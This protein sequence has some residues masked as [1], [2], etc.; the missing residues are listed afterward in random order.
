[1]EHCHRSLY[2]TRSKPVISAPC[3]FDKVHSKRSSSEETSQHSLKCWGCRYSNSLNSVGQRVTRYRRGESHVLTVKA[4]SN[5]VVIEEQRAWLKYTGRIR[6]K[7]TIPKDSTD[8]ILIL[9]NLNTA[10]P[11]ETPA[12]AKC[13]IRHSGLF[14]WRLSSPATPL[15]DGFFTV[16]S[17]FYI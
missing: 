13:A 11:T 16:G 1:M 2:V 9:P 5:V 12:R 7:G 3:N 4:T 14:L 15:F 10:L 8:V 17:I 6:R